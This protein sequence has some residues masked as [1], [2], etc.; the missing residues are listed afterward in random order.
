[1]LHTQQVSGAGGQTNDG[2]A[3]RSGG[4]PVE[5]IHGP[6]RE[7]K[8]KQPLCERPWSSDI[9]KQLKSTRA[10]RQI[11]ADIPEALEVLR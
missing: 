1:M 8:A 11:L 2:S 7:E 10:M 9:L 4:R 5:S 3:R 6:E